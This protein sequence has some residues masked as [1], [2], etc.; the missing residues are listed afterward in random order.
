MMNSLQAVR[1]ALTYI[2]CWMNYIEYLV[3]LARVT[4]FITI[5]VKTAAPLNLSAPQR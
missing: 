3:I 1:S 4:E 2:E 5:T